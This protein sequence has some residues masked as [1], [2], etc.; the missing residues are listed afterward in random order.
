M[1]NSNN[2]IKKQGFT[3][4]EAIIVM[5]ILGIIA[6]IMISNL[7]PVE[8]RDKGLQVLAKK[9]LNQLDI[10][11]QQI[12]I[13]NTQNG[14]LSTIYV[15]SSTTQ[16]SFSDSSKAQSLA[17]LYKK[18]L[19]TTRKKCTNTTD[20]GWVG[21]AGHA[22]ITAYGRY[23][24]KD[25]ACFGFSHAGLSDVIVTILPGETQTVNR[26]NLLGYFVLDINCLEEPNV[27]GKDRYVLPINQDGIFYD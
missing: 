1:F 24:L 11:T 9:T 6:T 15:P 7:K 19:V 23:Y 21:D 5:T 25:G 3:M 18:Y 13:N 16:F 2:K 14:K 17:T 12:M 26:S 20:C 10:A 4:A 8:F 22:G 27:F